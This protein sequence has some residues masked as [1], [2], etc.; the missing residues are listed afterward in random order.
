MASMPRTP[1]IR[2]PTPRGFRRVIERE[3]SARNRAEI[4]GWGAAGNSRRSGAAT[5][6]A[7]PPL[8]AA[9]PVA[10]DRG[11]RAGPADSRRRGR[12]GSVTSST[13]NPPVPS[14]HAWFSVGNAAAAVRPTPMPTA[15]SR[16]LDTTTG[17][18]ICSAIRNRAAN[19]AQRGDFQHRDVG[20]AG[21]D[22]TQRVVG[23]ADALVGG[24]R[25]RDAAA[26]FGQFG[27]GAARLLQVFQRPVGGQRVRRGH[28]LVEASSRRWR[29]PAPPG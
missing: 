28:R 21:S 29:P 6:R 15:E 14:P 27:D 20:A 10:P 13:N 9:R 26:Q 5:S 7:A 17:M 4:T 25:D 11:P 8:R 18:S 2:T 16:A 1:Q 3:V 19:P 22:D 23:L 12:H 24:H